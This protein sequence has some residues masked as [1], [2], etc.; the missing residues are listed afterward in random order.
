MKLIGVDPWGKCINIC[1]KDGFTGNDSF[2]LWMLTPTGCF[3]CVK[4]ANKNCRLDKLSQSFS[5]IFH[6]SFTWQKMAKSIVRIAPD[7]D[8]YLKNVFT[9][10]IIQVIAKF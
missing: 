6:N 3:L 8:E 1:T 9:I 2:L 10:Q 7:I 5:D 4:N